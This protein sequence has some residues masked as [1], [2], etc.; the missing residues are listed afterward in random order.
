MKKLITIL[1]A[2]AMACAFAPLVG[3]GSTDTIVV[4]LSPSATASISVDQS[5]WAPSCKLGETNSTSRATAVSG[6][7][8]RT[9]QTE[10]S[11][12]HCQVLKITR[13]TQLMF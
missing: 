2:I 1:I 8:G 4:T 9:P 12:Y 13:G 6:H 5:T 3:A 11:I 7:T 10:R